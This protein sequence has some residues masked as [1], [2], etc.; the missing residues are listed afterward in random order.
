M[1]A[2]RS[3]TIALAALVIAAG[4]STVARARPFDAPPDGIVTSNVTLAQVLTKY[5]SAR[6]AVDADSEITEEGA[7]DQGQLAGTYEILSQGAD[8][9]RTTT[10]G[11]FVNR[12][13][14]HGSVAWSENANGQSTTSRGDDALRYV[15]TR[16]L[17]PRLNATDCTLL[18]ELTSPVAAYVVDLKPAHDRDTYVFF[19]RKTGLIDR[20][21]TAYRGLRVTESFAD[22]KTVDGVTEPWVGQIRDGYSGD[23]LDWRV[24]TLQAG[25]ASDGSDFDMP[26]SRTLVEFPA[27]AQSVDLPIRVLDG[28]IVLRVMIDGKGY[29]FILDSGTGGILIDFTAAKEMGLHLYGQDH[30]TGVGHF[31]NAEAVVPEVDVGQLKMRDVAVGVL[32]FGEEQN[33]TKAV[34]L[35]GY[36]FIAG[37]ELRVDYEHSAAQ[38]MRAGL[39]VPPPDAVTLPAALDGR[40]PAVPAQ[41]GDANGDR[42]IFDTGAFAGFIFPGFAAAN[43]GAVRD[44]GARVIEEFLPGY[45]LGVGGAISLKPAEV[46]SFRLGSVSFDQPIVYVENGDPGSDDYDGLIGYDFLQYFN[47]VFDYADGLIFLEP[48]HLFKGISTKG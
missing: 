34:G 29:D 25:P 8:Y 42:F 17:D 40:V 31:D 13:G 19:D 48:N 41:V 3:T 15:G 14:R 44:R 2:R 4:N 38:A 12:D 7:L 10:L 46:N 20:T 43:A 1:F 21:E 28:Q 9:V 24:T 11:P 47:I 18:G 39:Y 6:G 30:G 23:D 22:Y 16:W 26:T 35:M 27:N 45:A 5:Q 36:D 33:G 37:M 32:T